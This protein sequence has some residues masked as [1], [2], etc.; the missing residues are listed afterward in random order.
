M[1]YIDQPVT[2]GFARGNITVNNEIDV[3]N[4]FMGFWKNFIK[5][6]QMEGFKVYS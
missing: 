6:F 4:Q 5:T 1:V 2:T 3:A